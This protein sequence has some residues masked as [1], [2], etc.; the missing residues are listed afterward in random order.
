LVFE[1]EREEPDSMT[2]R[3]RDPAEPLFSLPMIGWS[4]LQGGLAFAMLAT[5][6]VV[7]S[8]A[9]M[10]EAEL[11]A[12][13]FFALIT[14]VLALTLVNRSFGPSLGAAV[15][16]DNMALRTVIAAIAAVTALILLVPWAQALLKF[17]SIAWSDMA[18]A[19]GLGVLLLIALESCKTLARLPAVGLWLTTHFAQTRT[20]RIQ[21]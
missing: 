16:R 4:V 15:L 11:R 14:Q 9:G 2:R 10:A 5:V 1:A 19:A 18:L 13:I 6:F 21:P 12:L 3:P 17:G 20:T 8:R 7:E